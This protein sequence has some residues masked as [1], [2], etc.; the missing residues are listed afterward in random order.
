MVADSY[1]VSVSLD[2][3]G[4]DA[5]SSATLT[6]TMTSSFSQVGE[7]FNFYFAIGNRIQTFPKPDGRAT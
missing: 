5:D 3:S 6:G 4:A 2:K 7:F 1:Q